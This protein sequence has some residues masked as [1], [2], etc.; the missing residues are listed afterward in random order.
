MEDERDCSTPLDPR[1]SRILFMAAIVPHGWTESAK[2]FIACQEE[3]ELITAEEAPAPEYF[4]GLL[5]K[6]RTFH[7]GICLLIHF[8]SLKCVCSCNYSHFELGWGIILM[9][10]SSS[11]L[12][13]LTVHP[14]PNCVPVVPGLYKLGSPSRL[15]PSASAAGKKI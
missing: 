4:T 5:F 14:S 9:I 13:F 15:V 1:K 7:G 6:P 3:L 8:S 11:C 12:I 10:L 2:H